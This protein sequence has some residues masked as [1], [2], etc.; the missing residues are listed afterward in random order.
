MLVVQVR[1]SEWRKVCK[2]KGKC[3]KELKENA[4]KYVKNKY[5]I[6]VCDDEADAICIA[7]Y[8]NSLEIEE[9]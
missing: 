7:E 1:P 2:I 3:R 9:V 6:K 5:N 4:I 8:G